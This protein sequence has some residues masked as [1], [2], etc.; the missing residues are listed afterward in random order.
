MPE[1]RAVSKFQ[2]MHR[3]ISVSV[4]ADLTWQQVKDAVEKLRT[5]TRAGSIIESFRLFDIY[6]PKA[7]ESGERS[8][9]FRMTLVSSGE[10]SV[11]EQ[12]SEAAF[13]AVVDV[14]SGLGAKLRA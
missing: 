12:Q 2:P 3:D 5:G 4:P 1:A 10:E 14:L 13:E 8:M 11:T 6:A 9:A 7:G